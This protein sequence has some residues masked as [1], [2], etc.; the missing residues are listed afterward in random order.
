[1]AETAAALHPQLTD[2]LPFF[3]PAAD[4]SDPLMSFA[5][6]FLVIIIFLVGVLYLKLHS[7]PEHMA[8]HGRKLQMD[9]VAALGLIALFTHQ[10]A[11]W[12]A[13]LVLAMI[14]LPDFS[15]PMQSIANSLEKLSNKDDRSAES[16]PVEPE[17]IEAKVVEAPPVPTQTA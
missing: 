2:H 1:M 6:I 16:P 14:D 5:G 3:I 15:T 10:H 4:G 9:V 11:F 8:S 7:L 13:A 17:V 12:I